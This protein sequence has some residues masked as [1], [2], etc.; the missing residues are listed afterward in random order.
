MSCQY[1][2]IFGKPNEGIHSYRFAGMA[3]VDLVMTL[4]GSYF[5]AEYFEYSFPLVFLIVMVVGLVFHY[6]F[7]VETTLTKKIFNMNTS[8]VT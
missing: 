5:A 4:V 7:C 2:D 6:A 1:K 8:K 3:A